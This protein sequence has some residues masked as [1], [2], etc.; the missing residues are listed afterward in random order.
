VQD[1]IKVSRK[2]TLNLGVRYD[3]FGN[4]AGT[5]LNALNSPANLPN[6]P[7]IFPLPKQM[8]NVG[9]RW[10]SPTIRPAMAS[11]QFVARERRLRRH[12][13]ELLH[14]RKPV[15]RQV[16]LQPLPPAWNIWTASTW[17]LHGTGSLQVERCTQNFTPL[18]I[19]RR[20]AQTN[21]IMVDAYAPKSF[22]SLVFST[23]YS[24]TPASKCAT[25]ALA[26]RFAHPASVEFDYRLR[27]GALPL[28]RTS[29]HR[30]S[31]PPCRLRHPHWRSSTRNVPLAHEEIWPEGFTGGVIT[32]EAPALPAPITAALSNSFTASLTVSSS[33]RTTPSR[34][35]WTTL[36]TT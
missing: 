18:P 9:P 10:V 4:P 25:S 2:L 24:K 3:F 16:V 31:L 36:Q 5:K 21:Q 23:K 20:S 35:R 34:R 8:E 1:D 33:A 13:A 12:S 19:R 30:T 14:Q 17:L 11:G 26:H 22:M 29:V 32:A 7:L 6:S 15:Q 27:H 28:R